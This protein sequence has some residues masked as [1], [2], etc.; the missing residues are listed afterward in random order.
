MPDLKC[1]TK[2]DISSACG[3]IGLKKINHTHHHTDIDLKCLKIIQYALR[4]PYLI[5]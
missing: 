5:I 2:S 1:D 4:G 3:R